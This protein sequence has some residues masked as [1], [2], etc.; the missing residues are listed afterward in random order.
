MQPPRQKLSEQVTQM[1]ARILPTATDRL[2]EPQI[3]RHFVPSNIIA[4]LGYDP[5]R[6]CLQAEYFSGHVYRI[7]GVSDR[8]YRV[9]LAADKF[10]QVYQQ[11]ILDHHPMTQIGTLPPVFR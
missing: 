2:S 3:D 10:D 11:D 1:I 7:D 5:S 6:Q 8:A 4:T 9:L